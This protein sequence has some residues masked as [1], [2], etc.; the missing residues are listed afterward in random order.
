MAVH[1]LP[2][3]D[4]RKDASRGFLRAGSGEGWNPNLGCGSEKGFLFS[5]VQ[6]RWHWRGAELGT[7]PTEPAQPHQHV[8]H[9]GVDLDHV[10]APAGRQPLPMPPIALGLRGAAIRAAIKFARL[11]RFGGALQ[12]HSSSRAR[13]R[14]VTHDAYW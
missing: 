5:A 9:A 6:W 7:L 11:G 4:S 8:E 13:S 1:G 2:P 10:A 12:D 3:M 14:R